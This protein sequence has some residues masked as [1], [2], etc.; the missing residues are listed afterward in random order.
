MS[1]EYRA[2]WTFPEDSWD[3]RD[4]GAGWGMIGIFS[5]RFEAGLGVTQ[6]RGKSSI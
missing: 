2:G 6:F 5:L 4:R 1:P 3:V